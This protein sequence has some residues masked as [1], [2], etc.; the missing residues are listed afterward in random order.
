MQIIII[1]I[2]S[3]GRGWRTRFASLYGAFQAD[4]VDQFELDV[5]PAYEGKIFFRRVILLVHRDSQP[6]N[7]LM[8]VNR[9]VNRSS[10]S[11]SHSTLLIC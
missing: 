5:V 8:T 11:I 6:I 4:E 2:I 7:S 10:Q 3:Y 1:A 9:L